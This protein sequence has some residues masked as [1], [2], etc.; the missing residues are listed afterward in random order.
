MNWKLSSKCG[1]DPNLFAVL[2]T[3]QWDPFFD[4]KDPDDRN[5]IKAYCA[6][7][8]VRIECQGAGRHEEGAWGGKPSRSRKYQ[9]AVNEAKILEFLAQTKI[10]SPGMPSVPNVV[11][12]D[13]CA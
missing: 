12:E 13:D 7:C 1:N 6:D 5:W 2:K 10:Q 11:Q 3:R 8:P 4:E 9:A